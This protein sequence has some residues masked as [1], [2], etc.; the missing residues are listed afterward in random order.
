MCIALL[1]GGG[2]A[3]GGREGGRECVCGH[4]DKAQSLLYVES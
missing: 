3:E 2:G 1:S 4:S